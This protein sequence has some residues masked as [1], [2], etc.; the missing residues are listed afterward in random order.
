M[1][2][3]QSKI[4]LFSIVSVQIS[5]YN[6]FNNSME[7]NVKRKFIVKGLI[8]IAVLGALLSFVSCDEWISDTINVENNSG[9]SVDV[10]IEYGDQQLPRGIMPIFMWH[11]MTRINSIKYASRPIKIS[12]I[13]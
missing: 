11:S 7:E 4:D 3:Y 12:F 8:V 13:M 5:R 9:S 1:S 2:F 10:Y 6:V